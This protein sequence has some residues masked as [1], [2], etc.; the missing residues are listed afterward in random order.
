[1]VAGADLRLAL[2]RKAYFIQAQ[3]QVITRISL[4]IHHQ[5]S[6]PGSRDSPGPYEPVDLLQQATHLPC[7]FTQHF[8]DALLIVP[9]SPGSH[10]NVLVLLLDAWCC[11]QHL[12][13]EN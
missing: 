5:E 6:T 10:T 9:V 13:C 1:M 4:R 11:L 3:Q 8:A 2:S 7:A 12:S